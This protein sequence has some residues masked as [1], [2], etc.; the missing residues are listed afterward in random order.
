MDREHFVFR[1]GLADD[2]K[3]LIDFRTIPLRAIL[4]LEKLPPLA[5]EWDAHEV[6]GLP[7]YHRVFGNDKYGNCTIASQAHQT[8]VFE[9]FEQGKM[10]KITDD[11]VNKEYFR[12]SKGKDTGLFL[13][14][15]MKEWRNTGWVLDGKHYN[16]YAFAGVDV[17]DRVQ[18]KYSIQLLNGLI[19]GMM[20]FSSDI[21][22]F[23]RNEPWHL[24]GNNGSFEGGHAVYGFRYTDSDEVKF[25]DPAILP[26]DRQEV[27]FAQLSKVTRTL[28]WNDKGM[29][30]M[31]WGH[32]QFGDWEF[33]EAR[34]MQAFAIVDNRNKW[35]GDKSPVNIQLLDSYLKEI[36]GR[37]STGGCC[38]SRMIKELVHKGVHECI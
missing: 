30:V 24:T 32:K 37:S 4:R 1:P 38:I 28:S 25:I 11:D 2:G 33:W 36:T 23:R 8:L 34:L 17:K 12:Q 6:V 3:P 22:Q 21:D 29:T 20:V 9:Q 18:I 14:Q 15:V 31:T 26:V 5:S 10:I 13:T 16:I 19:G 35:M 7:N 27:C